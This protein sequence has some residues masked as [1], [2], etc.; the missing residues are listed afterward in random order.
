MDGSEGSTTFVDSSDYHHPMTATGTVQIV[1]SLSRWGNGCG[2]FGG[3]GTAQAN[4]LSTPAAPEL[5]FSSSPF[6]MEAWVYR[7][8]PPTTI[9]V[10]IDAWGSNSQQFIWLFYSG[11]YSFYC[12]TDG[13]NN[14]NFG[15]SWSPTNNTWYHVAVDRDSGGWIRLYINGALWAKENHP[16]LYAS[17]TAPICIGSESSAWDGSWGGYIDEV[18]ITTGIARYASDAGYTVPTAPY[19][20]RSL[21]GPTYN[22]TQGMMSL[23]R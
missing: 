4:K 1:N 5:R 23:F 6:T 16:S 13:M 19:P 2:N 12:S 20:D 21:A 7:T 11:Q 22:P 18:R 8:Q 10:I 17:T 14:P 9:P 3:T 15:A